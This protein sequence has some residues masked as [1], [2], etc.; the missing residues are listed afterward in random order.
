M[1]RIGQPPEGPPDPDG[2]L[3]DGFLDDADR[4]KFPDIRSTAP[5]ALPARGFTFRDPRL[6]EL[7]FR[8]QARNW[9]DTLETGAREAWDVWRRDRFHGSAA[10]EGT[11]ASYLT[12]R[13]AAQA[14]LADSGDNAALLAADAWVRERLAEVGIDLPDTL[15]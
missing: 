7:L 5:E 11:L 6:P 3:Y 9:P 8:Y 13:E 10:A 4:R 12:E 15:A 14:M 1:P 2:A